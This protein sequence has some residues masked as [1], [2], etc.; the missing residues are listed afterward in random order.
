MFNLENC[1]ILETINIA[2]AEM[3]NKDL[4]EVGIAEQWFYEGKKGNNVE[5]GLGRRGMMS[6]HRRG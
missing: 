6:E 3:E 5:E 2:L 1:R 4:K